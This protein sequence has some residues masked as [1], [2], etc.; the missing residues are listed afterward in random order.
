MKRL[1]SAE[2]DDQV[3]DHL[4]GLLGAGNGQGAGV[5]GHT[6]CPLRGM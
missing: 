1:T 6:M 3:T 2:L 5:I 4:V